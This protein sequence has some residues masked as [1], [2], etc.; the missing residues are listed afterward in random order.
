M[1][2]L[3]PEEGTTDWVTSKL[4][5]KIKEFYIAGLPN[6][7]VSTVCATYEG[8]GD[9]GDLSDL[10]LADNRGTLVSVDSSELDYLEGLLDIYVDNM[11]GWGWVNNDGGKVIIESVISSTGDI[12]LNSKLYYYVTSSELESS[13]TGDGKISIDYNSFLIK[14]MFLGIHYQDCQHLVC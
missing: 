10:W 11:Y 9:S 14:T 7:L 4:I 8:S 13:D 12:K 6:K 2:E 3:E 5:N 1:R